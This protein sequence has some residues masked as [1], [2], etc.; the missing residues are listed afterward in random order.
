MNATI[1]DSYSTEFDSSCEFY[2]VLLIMSVSCNILFMSFVFCGCVSAL[3]PERSDQPLRPIMS[4]NTISCQADLNSS[5]IIVI[6][7]DDELQ[8]IHEK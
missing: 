7:P 5:V 2:K 6:N 8:V 1:N 4:T 3:F